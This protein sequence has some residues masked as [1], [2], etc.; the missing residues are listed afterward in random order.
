MKSLI[1]DM[2]PAM[3][4]CWFETMEI[5]QFQA[6]MAQLHFVRLPSWGHAPHQFYVAYDESPIAG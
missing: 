5:G 1:C 3:S 4:I 6:L 2:I